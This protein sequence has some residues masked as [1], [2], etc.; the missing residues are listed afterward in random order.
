MARSLEGERGHN[1]IPLAPDFTTTSG[2]SF[3]RG[4]WT[5][6]YEFR[7][8]KSRPANNF[9]VAKGYFINDA[10]VNYQWKNLNIGIAAENLFN[11]AWNE[12]QFAT[13]SRLKNE[14]VSVEEI[15]FIP[16]TPFFFEG[17]GDGAVLIK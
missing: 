11:S 14:K 6:S 15:H 16:D 9:I 13:E 2:L 5:G 7:Y 17:H 12:T 3:Q 4:S 8:M 1:Y 10:N